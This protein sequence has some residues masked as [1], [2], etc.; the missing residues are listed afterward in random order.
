MQEVPD[1]G[2]AQPQAVFGKRIE[3]DLN[4]LHQCKKNGEA[5]ARVK[6]KKHGDGSC[7]TDA[8]FL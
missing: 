2:R 4:H 3:G 5:G 1:R 6:C 8:N 7:E